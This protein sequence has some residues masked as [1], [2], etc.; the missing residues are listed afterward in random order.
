MKD[1]LFCADG[2]QKSN[3]DFYYNP[4]RLIPLQSY[5]VPSVLPAFPIS[6]FSPSRSPGA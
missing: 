1:S 5:I 2:S 3:W 4:I 6:L